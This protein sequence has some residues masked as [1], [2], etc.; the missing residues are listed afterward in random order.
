MLNT[1]TIDTK[2]PK[3][4]RRPKKDNNKT[5]VKYKPEFVDLVKSIYQDGYADHLEDFYENYQ[6][7]QR[8]TPE[9]LSFSSTHLKEAFGSKMTEKYTPEFLLYLTQLFGN[10]GYEYVENKNEPQIINKY[11]QSS[12]YTA[13]YAKE[14]EKSCSNVKKFRANAKTKNINAI[15]QIREDLSKIIEL[16]GI[17]P[18][19]S[20]SKICL[21]CY[22]IKDL[23]NNSECCL[24]VN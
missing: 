1:Y 16:N 2:E 14:R 11:P 10:K 22:E 24:K 20:N 8:Y 12:R 23:N 3:K 4:K 7:N 19:L 18:S 5:V 6:N 13:E 17:F 9:F 15:K 21:S